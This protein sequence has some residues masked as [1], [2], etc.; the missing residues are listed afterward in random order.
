M[1]ASLEQRAEWLA[2]EFWDRLDCLESWHR[3]VRSEHECARRKLNGADPGKT[4]EIHEAWNRYC[5]VIAELDRTTTE[6]DALCRG[7][8]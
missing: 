3:Q 7:A 6:F 5:E 8:Y 2:S 4:Q 1:S